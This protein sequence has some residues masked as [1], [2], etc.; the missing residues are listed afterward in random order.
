MEVRRR[1]LRRQLL[2]C[3]CWIIVVVTIKGEAATRGSNRSQRSP[4]ARLQAKGQ[5]ESGERCATPHPNAASDGDSHQAR[6]I[7]ASAKKNLHLDFSGRIETH[8]W[9]SPDSAI[10]QRTTPLIQLDDSPRMMPSLIVG[11]DYDFAKRWYGAT[12]LSATL[13]F[14]RAGRAEPAGITR[15]SRLLLPT[16]MDLARE[17]GLIAAA[18]DEERFATANVVEWRWPLRRNSDD[19]NSHLHKFNDDDSM[20]LRMRKTDAGSASATVS[21]PLHRR[22]HWECRLTNVGET[23]CIVKPSSGKEEEEVDDWWIPNVRVD[24]LGQMESTNQVWLTEQK[25]RLVMTVRRRLNWSALGF[26]TGNADDGS[27]PES[28]RLRFQVQNIGPQSARTTLSM[29]SLLERPFASARVL[30]RHD[31]AINTQ[32]LEQRPCRTQHSTF[33][34]P[35]HFLNPRISS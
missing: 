6:R 2:G 1:I 23:S 7:N 15:S 20:L 9:G 34:P 14:C 8:I 17:Q 32:F 3:C 29:E 27:I 18:G 19:A 5:R 24:A 26:F 31:V 25:V 13:R 22:I 12:L 35:E 10:D 11:A 16:S 4:F 33:G 28:T 30:V 21:L